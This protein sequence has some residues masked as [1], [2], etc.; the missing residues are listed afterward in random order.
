M[1]AVFAT[2]V[3][4]GLATAPLTAADGIRPGLW[5]IATVVVNNGMTLPLQTNSRCLTAEQAGDLG[6][7]TPSPETDVSSVR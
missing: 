1:R 6:E 5:K 7:Q 3:C 4:V 2:A